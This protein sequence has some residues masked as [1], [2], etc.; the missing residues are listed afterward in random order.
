HYRIIRPDGG[1]RLLYE[2]SENFLDENG[3]FLFAQGTMQDVTELWA[4]KAALVGRERELKESEERFRDFAEAASDYQWE[5]DE[6]FAVSQM[7]GGYARI[8]ARNVTSIIGLPL[9]GVVGLDESRLDEH[10][11]NFRD[12][13]RAHRPFRDF[14]YFLVDHKGQTNF[15]R[16]NGDP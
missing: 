13:L 11:S 16:A 7:S 12:T 4:T 9:W 3:R 10:W 15:R 6:N 2:I 1:E 14:R 5:M 8:A